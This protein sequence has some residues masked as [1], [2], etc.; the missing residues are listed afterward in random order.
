MKGRI[1]H[2]QLKRGMSYES[3]VMFNDKWVYLGQFSSEAEAFQAQGI[4]LSLLQRGERPIPPPVPRVQDG[5]EG[6][7]P[8]P[9]TDG[10][11]VYDIDVTVKGEREVVPSFPTEAQAVR[12]RAE[13]L[14]QINKGNLMFR[15]A[16]TRL[17]KQKPLGA[18]LKMDP[19]PSSDILFSTYAYQWY[20]A[21]KQLWSPQTL[22]EYRSGMKRF[23]NVVLGAVPVAAIDQRHLAALDALMTRHKVTTKRRVKIRR[24][25]TKILHSTSID[26]LRTSHPASYAWCHAGTEAS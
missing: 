8:R 14:D 4:A 23:I 18:K 13:W 1:V 21:R 7:I 12:A 6:I 15:P 17:P 5:T 24:T 16:T 20:R 11:V 10:T 9:L 26:G 25:L 22:Y 3:Y 19:P 2:R